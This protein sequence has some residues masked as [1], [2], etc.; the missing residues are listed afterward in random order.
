MSKMMFCPFLLEFLY[1]IVVVV[2]ALTASSPVPTQDDHQI[3]PFVPVIQAKS[4]DNS[5]FRFK[6][7]I[8]NK[9]LVELIIGGTGRSESTTH[10]PEST[11]Y[12]RR[13]LYI[14]DYLSLS[15]LPIWLG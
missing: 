1:F 5:H 9:M 2:V 11:S 7:L 6:R 10:K 3:D 14:N 4:A 13:S 15:R 12:P 8:F